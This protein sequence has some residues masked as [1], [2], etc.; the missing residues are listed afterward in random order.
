[1]MLTLSLREQ[2]SFTELLLNLT[3]MDFLLTVLLMYE[4]SFY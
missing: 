1:M 3:F 4:L 2:D